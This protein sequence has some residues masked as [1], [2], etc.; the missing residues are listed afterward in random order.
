VTRQQVGRH[1]IGRG[2]EARRGQGV[3]EFTLLVPL[4]LV[5]LLGM[6]ELGF[7]F[8]HQLTLQYATREGARI[9][10]DLVNGGGTLGCASD[11]SLNRGS[12]DPIIIEAVDRV[13]TSTGSPIP[14]AQ[15]TRIRI[16]KADSSGKDTLGLDNDWTYTAVPFTLS[17]GTQVNFR[18]GVT[19]WDACSR[20]NRAGNTYANAVD[21]IGVS[22]FYTYRL[23]TPLAGALRLIG[24]SQAASIGMTDVTVMQFNPT[25]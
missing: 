1:S 2:R 17:D 24:G 23:T 7:A 18:P 9:G 15:I 5:L 6:V 13:L 19:S 10:A 12:V 14:L 8:N 11:E 21:S 20:S 3:V 22:I 4:F 16:F 25:S